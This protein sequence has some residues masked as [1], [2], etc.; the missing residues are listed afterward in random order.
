MIIKRLIYCSFFLLLLVGL[1]FCAID[2][3]V[4][5]N[6]HTES[7]INQGYT[8]QK[9]RDKTTAVDQQMISERDASLTMADLLSRMAGVSVT[10]SGRNLKVVVRGR[11]SINMSSDPLFVV[12]DRIMGYGFSSV[13]FLT[14]MMIKRISVLKDGA[15]AAAYGAR[16]ANGVILIELKNNSTN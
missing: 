6:Q 14:P 10:G 2:K 16:G 1:A 11:N 9:K 7:I 3:S 5:G 13:D 12:D 15:S 8:K 4:P